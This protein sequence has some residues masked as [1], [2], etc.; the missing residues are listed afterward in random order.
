MI[1][2]SAMTALMTLIMTGTTSWAWVMPEKPQI[3]TENQVENIIYKGTPVSA[4]SLIAKSTFALELSMEGIP[5]S[6]NLP[7]CS[8]TLIAKDVLLTAAHCLH[9]DAKIIYRVKYFDS[10][11][12]AHFI[13]VTDKKI[14]EK[15]KLSE[16]ERGSAL[17]DHDIALIRLEK[18]LPGGI[19]A[20]L[21]SAS[22]KIED[23]SSVIVAGYGLNGR[24]LK[25]EEVMKDPRVMALS[26]KMKQPGL[27]EDELMNLMGQLISILQQ[28]P[29]LWTRASTSAEQKAHQDVPQMLLRGGQAICSGDSG[30]PSYILTSNS[31]LMVVGVHSTGTSGEECGM[32]RNF[33]GQS[34]E[35][36]NDTFVPFYISWIQKNIAQLKK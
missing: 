6:F 18:A 32:R 15:Y 13:K 34:L 25:K 2:K 29:L 36:G 1:T 10:T 23:L 12:Q 35:K 27:S 11:G 9:D 24:A 14:H 16:D 26:A 8:A 3:D 19:V 30:G 21:P 28:K 33:F 22:L 20:K 7:S 4:K 17:V 31:S 5:T